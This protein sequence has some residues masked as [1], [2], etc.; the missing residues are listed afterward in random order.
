MPASLLF[1]QIMLLIFLD[2]CKREVKVPVFK[3]RTVSFGA[4]SVTR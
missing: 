1:I 3:C 2:T 4:L